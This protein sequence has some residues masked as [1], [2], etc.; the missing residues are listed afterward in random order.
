MQHLP[1]RHQNR[2][3]R[4]PEQPAGPGAGCDYDLVGLYLS[5]VGIDYDAGTVLF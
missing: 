3:E 1:S 4:R 2:L 5:A